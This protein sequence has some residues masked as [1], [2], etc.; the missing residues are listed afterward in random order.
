MFNLWSSI[1]NI[2][3][4]IRLFPHLNLSVELTHTSNMRFMKFDSGVVEKLR[5]DDDKDEGDW[6]RKSL[7]VNH[8]I[9][10]RFVGVISLKMPRNLMDIWGIFKR[11]LRN[12]EIW[13]REHCLKMPRNLMPFL[14]EIQSRNGEESSL[15]L[16]VKWIICWWQC[17]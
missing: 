14:S 3:F 1:F 15:K 11:F 16:H 2:Y 5:E 13:L 7:K 17:V 8:F 9:H 12:K 4:Y 6:Q 10:S